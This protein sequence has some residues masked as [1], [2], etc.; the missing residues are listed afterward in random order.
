M[1]SLRVGVRYYIQNVDSGSF[2]ELPDKL[3]ESEVKTRPVKVSEKQLV[4]NVKAM[5]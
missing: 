4:G 5:T 2:L 3:A 1:V